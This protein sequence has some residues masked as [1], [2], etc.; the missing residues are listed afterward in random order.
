MAGMRTGTDYL[1]SLDDGRQVFLDGERVGRVTE[2]PAFRAAARSM[3]NLFD[4]AATPEL[5]ERMTFT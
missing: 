5:R 2:H 4:L 1:R 3:A